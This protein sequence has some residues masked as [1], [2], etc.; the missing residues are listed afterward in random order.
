M[1]SRYEDILDLISQLKVTLLGDRQTTANATTMLTTLFSHIE[2]SIDQ[3]TPENL[4]NLLEEL[5]KPIP[6]ET[7]K[8][9]VFMEIITFHNQLDLL[10]MIKILQKIIRDPRVTGEQA[11]D[12]LSRRDN[13]DTIWAAMTSA[14]R[15]DDALQYL[16]LL[17]ELRK[18]GVSESQIIQLLKYQ[19]VKHLRLFDSEGE[20]PIFEIIN[21]KLIAKSDNPVIFSAAIS[22]IAVSP[23]VLAEMGKEDLFSKIKLLKPVDATHYLKQC[24]D[25]T[26]P[27]GKRFRINE[28]RLPVPSS[29][30]WGILKRIDAAIK[31]IDPARALN[32]CDTQRVSAMGKFG[33]PAKRLTLHQRQEMAWADLERF[34][35]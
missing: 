3:L 17:A 12:C 31:E 8:R 27:L 23:G 33:E 20:R 28:G 10:L 9:N 16:D 2:K 7:W 29:T 15:D 34:E 13:R 26:T 11:L 21:L 6:G 5:S 4:H 14:E 22:Y 19:P 30:Y 1:Q 35:L 25:S 32:N 24:L 18:K